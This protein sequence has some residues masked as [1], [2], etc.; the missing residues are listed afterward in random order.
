MG[1][2]RLLLAFAVLSH[3][4]P[5]MDGELLPGVVS[6]R[7]FFVVSG[8]YMSLILEERYARGGLWLFYS[9]RLLR[10][11][12]AYLVVA[13][14][15]LALV[16]ALDA[17][18]FMSRDDVL[19]A[20]AI[21]PL[22]FAG[23]ALS[24]LTL[25]GQDL[26]FLLDFSE[27]FSPVWSPCQECPVLGFWMSLVPQA[28]S[29][30]LELWFYLLAPFLVR[31][32]APALL[33][34]GAASLAL[35]TALG[36]GGADGANTAHHLFPAQLHLFLLGVLSQR[37]GRWGALS[38]L[39]RGWGLAALGAL[40]ALVFGYRFMA[41]P[42]RFPLAA[43]AFAGGMPLVFGALKDAAWDRGLGELSYPFYLVQFLVLGA[44]E[45]AAPELG[46]VGVVALVL[47]A[48][49]GLYL[50]VDRPVTGWRW[51]RLAAASAPAGVGTAT[52]V[53]QAAG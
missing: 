38:S 49:V 13:A 19:G 25:M 15:S 26:L 27:S 48:A 24:N 40:C 52:A 1:I 2:I 5:L 12:P 6:V 42:W 22:A 50:L 4:A 28:W 47:A 8:F 29:V 23:L 30:S 53:P 3:H 35:H 32:R 16:L 51:R 43:L 36:M 10:L 18:S 20:W 14:L 7:L 45:H 39:P 44:L 46:A 33:G 41:D 34:L 9:N 11:L 31:L 37:L 21:A 17:H